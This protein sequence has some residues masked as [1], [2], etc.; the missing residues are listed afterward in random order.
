MPFI[1]M[2]IMADQ[3]RPFKLKKAIEIQ[4][5]LPP[6]LKAIEKMKK[7][8]GLEMCGTLEIV[9]TW[10]CGNEPMWHRGILF[11]ILKSRSRYCTSNVAM[12]HCGNVASWN[13]VQHPEKQ[14][15]SHSDSEQPRIE[16]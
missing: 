10:I 7:N 13:H 1:E 8:E 6:F 3:Q 4:P 14:I 9:A 15:P 12:W 16:M 11:N 5:F 2:D